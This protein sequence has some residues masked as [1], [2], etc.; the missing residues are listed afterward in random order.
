VKKG[1][2]RTATPEEIALASEYL[3]DFGYIA[4]DS[5]SPYF[6]GFSVPTNSVVHHSLHDH[7]QFLQQI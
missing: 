4:L 7:N 6:G 5:R 3:R 1:L 2:N